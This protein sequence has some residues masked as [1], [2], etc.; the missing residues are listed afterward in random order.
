MKFSLESMSKQVLEKKSAA[1]TEDEIN[2]IKEKLKTI[3][4]KEKKLEHEI[5]KLKTLPQPKQYEVFVFT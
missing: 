2:K 4:N 5:W 1:T 3:H